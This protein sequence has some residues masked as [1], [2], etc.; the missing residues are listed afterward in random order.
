MTDV[1]NLDDPPDLVKG[2]Y[3]TDLN[4]NKIHEAIL[5]RLNFFLNT[6]DILKKRIDDLEKSISNNDFLENEITN[7]KEELKTYK[8][9]LYDYEN[10][11]SYNKYITESKYYI[12]EYNKI[13]SNKSKNIVFFLK[14]NDKESPEL[15]EKRLQI[16]KEYLKLCNNYIRLDITHKK[17]YTVNCPGCGIEINKISSDD[18]IGLSICQDCGYERE[19]ISHHSSYNDNQRVNI[20]N[21]NNYDDCDNFRKALLRFQG[22]QNHQP[23]LKLYDQL[24]KYFSSIGKPIG[25]EIIKL[26]LTPDGKKSGTSRQMMF[27][28]LADTNNS[29]YYDDINLIL[30]IYWGWKLPDISYLEERIIEEYISTQ[31]VYNSIQ[32]KDR[33]ASLN[34]Q[35]RL[36]VHLK[37]VG[38]PCSK[39]DFKIQTSRDSL[40]FHNEMWKIMCDKTGVKFHAVI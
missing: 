38:Y 14:S 5:T 34:I 2:T 37:S 31:H 35:F 9:V 16:I 30:N 8:D 32:N 10:K 25:S 21:R 27:E 11:I 39:D 20:G 33:N 3:T 29:A 40:I 23:P 13:A 18:D 17:S 1:K 15:I 22:K 4:I 28:A 12:E 26:P 24:D 7:L 6:T 36:F 19:I